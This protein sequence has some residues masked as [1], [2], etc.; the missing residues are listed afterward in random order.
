MCPETHKRFSDEHV[1]W[2]YRLTNQ[3][4]GERKLLGNVKVRL[5]KNSFDSTFDLGGWLSTDPIMLSNSSRKAEKVCFLALGVIRTGVFTS[6]SL[7]GYLE[8][9]VCLFC[10]QMIA[11]R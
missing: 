2:C 9:R 8:V 3:A 7:E 10:F 5:I 1:F 4:G 6:H 11:G